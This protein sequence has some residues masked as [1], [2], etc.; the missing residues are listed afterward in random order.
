ME[1]TQKPSSRP[2]REEDVDLGK[3]FYKTGGAINNFFI[4][5]GGVFRAFGNFLIQVL[6]FLRRNFKWLALGTLVGIGYGYY[7]VYREGNNYHSSM[8]VK[9]NYNS[10]KALYNTA[11]YLNA[12]VGARQRTEL[13]R[14]FGITEKEASSLKTF[15]VSPVESEI[16][17]ADLYKERFLNLYH[18]TRVRMDTFWIKT[19]SF[20]D[21][22]NTLTKYDYPVHE[23]KVTSNLPNIFGKL[24]Q[25]IIASVG[26][27]ETLKRQQQS[28]NESSQLEV[29]LLESSIK[30][31]DTL[32][33]S[34]NKRL[35]AGAQSREGTNVTL[36][37]GN[38]AMA[39]P[40]LMLYDKM[41]QLKDELKMVKS[42][43]A[44]GQDILQ[45]L[46][47]FNAVGRSEGLLQN[48]VVRFAYIGF[49]TV[50]AIL[51]LVLLNNYLSGLEKAKK[52]S[53]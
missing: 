50:L 47:P 4:W 31:L 2:N 49:L 39:N 30:S 10:S 38:V 33:S 12:L 45:V 8:T 43:A 19:I 44:D 22:K 20:E 35:Q 3:L 53:A 24:Q 28:G 7:L 29:N 40:E 9:A 48:K 5:L 37:E 32:R 34:Y 1:Q 23:I 51:L 46:A 6:F 25:G 11:D 15:T 13:A 17:V 16:I 18:N 14:F 27:I 21:F 42:E 36:L 26:S 52:A 41:L